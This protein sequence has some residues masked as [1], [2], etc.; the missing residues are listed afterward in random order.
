M[1]LPLN[2]I[3]PVV[4]KILEWVVKKNFFGEKTKEACVKV[5]AKVS[6]KKPVKEIP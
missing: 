2:I 3:I 5:I 6:E 4:I 1:K